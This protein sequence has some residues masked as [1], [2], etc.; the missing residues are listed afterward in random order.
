MDPSGML[1]QADGRVPK[2]RYT[3]PE[4][5]RLELDRLW[6]R[7]WQIA[8]REEE[9][10]EPGAYLE[11]EI[12]D[13]SI[14][15]VRGEDGRIAG[16][17][18]ACLHRGTR[19]GA[20]KG[21]FADGEIVCRYHAWRYAFDGRLVHVV[22][23]HEFPELPEGLRLAEVQ[24]DTWGGFVFVNLDPGAGPLLEFLG[25]IPSWLGAY[26]LEDMRLRAHLSTVLPANWKC[27]V[28]AFNESYHV[29]G[30]HPQILAWTDDVG[31]AYEQSGNH[32]RYG[33]LDGARRELRPSPRLGLGEDDYDEG[34]ILA[35]LVGG[36]GGAFLG[37][38]RALVEEMRAAGLGPGEL[39]PAY[40]ARRMA[41]LAERGLDVSGFVPDQMTSAEDVFWF[42]NI[43]GPIYPG[44]AIL[45]RARPHGLDP[46]QAIH[47][48][49]VLEWPRP[50]A[51]RREAKRRFT[52][53]WTA[54]DWGEI[55][56]QDYETLAEVQRGMRSDGFDALRL[57]PRQESNILHMHR[58]I[59]RYLTEERP[60]V[61]R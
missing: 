42:P 30:T 20:G 52:E 61:T 27:V 31:I 41:L 19:L 53:D 17:R 56:T 33:R 21:C 43:V 54:R 60:D 6:G 3:S 44:S 49:W 23:A 47:D 1:V 37:D 34:E 51:D 14:L 11:Y 7:V 2:R 39:L 29:Q 18:N 38:E 15:L 58:V 10:A 48:T 32:A 36:L 55:T 12:G 28:D 25:P 26:H 16:L 24:V 13:Q 40:Q 46:E 4:F 50:G 9:L 8:G 59:D 45:F 35:A 5:A 22:D 57:N